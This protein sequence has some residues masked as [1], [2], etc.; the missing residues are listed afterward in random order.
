MLLKI[1]RLPSVY[2]KSAQNP[3][4]PCCINNYECIAYNKNMIHFHAFFTRKGLLFRLIFKLSLTTFWNF[5]NVKLPTT[6]VTTRETEKNR[7]NCAMTYVRI[8]LWLRRNKRYRKRSFIKMSIFFENF[9][10]WKMNKMFLLFVIS[11]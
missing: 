2:V 6:H 7:N 3:W 10:F 9:V 8:C 5:K 1:L 11:F 4:H